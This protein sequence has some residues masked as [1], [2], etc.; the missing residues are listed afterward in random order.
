MFS[1]KEF[2]FDGPPWDAADLLGRGVAVDG[3]GQRLVAAV[4]A[5]V[6]VREARAVPVHALLG[7]DAAVVQVAVRRVVLD[8]RSLLYHYALSE[9]PLGARVLILK[10]LYR[11]RSI[12][13]ERS[14][15]I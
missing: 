14:P 9:R 4:R 3:R 11:T 1:G 2:L 5:V 15:A 7:A 13:V 8:Q 12:G 10:V 6:R